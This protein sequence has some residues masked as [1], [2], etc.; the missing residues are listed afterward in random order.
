[1]SNFKTV[2]ISGYG[3]SIYWADYEPGK[4]LLSFSSFPDDSLVNHPLDRRL[5]HRVP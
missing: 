5:V 4:P 1:M 3:P 2:S